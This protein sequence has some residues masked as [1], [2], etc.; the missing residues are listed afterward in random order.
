MKFGMKSRP[1]AFSHFLD[2]C[3][4]ATFLFFYGSNLPVVQKQRSKKKIIDKKTV[5]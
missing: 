3:H 5:I 1:E 2:A 4:A